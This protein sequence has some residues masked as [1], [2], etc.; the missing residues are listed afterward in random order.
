VVQLTLASQGT[1]NKEKAFPKVHVNDLVVVEFHDHKV[2]GDEG[3]E[4]KKS[5]Q[6][7]SWR[8]F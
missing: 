3:R 5:T 1:K 4:C 2:E 7:S 6:P 8:K